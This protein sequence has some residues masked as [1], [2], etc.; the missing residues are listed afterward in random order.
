MGTA[1][2]AIKKAAPGLAGAG[3]AKIVDITLSSSYA[4]GG[5][6]VTL[7]SLGMSSLDALMLTGN[8]AGYACEVVHG[9][10]PT[11][12]PKIRL[13]EDKATAA[14]TP[15]GEEAAATNVTSVVLRAIAYGSPHI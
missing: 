12:D 11:T 10:T 3:V 5:D 9:A 1:T 6:T 14:A 2:V 7:T 4:T 8:A 13:W 15:L